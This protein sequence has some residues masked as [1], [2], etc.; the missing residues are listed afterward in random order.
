M[1]QLSLFHQ[2]GK[3][4]KMD[5]GVE[6]GKGEWRFLP[7]FHSFLLFVLS[8]ED[9]Q[10]VAF[11]AVPN[12]REGGGKKA[13]GKIYILSPNPPPLSPSSP[14]PFDV[15][16]CIFCTRRY[17]GGQILGIGYTRAGPPCL[18]S[19]FKQTEIR[20]KLKEWQ[21]KS[22]KRRNSASGL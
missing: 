12:R 11:V 20:T 10:Q 3:W 16:H 1:T 22:H 17:K 7:F 8:T 19:F 4:S 14:F 13:E 18:P 5:S 2:A 9:D 6:N 21:L 15:R